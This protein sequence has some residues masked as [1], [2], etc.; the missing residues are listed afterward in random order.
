MGAD[1]G[2][3]LALLGATN[4]NLPLVGLGLGLKGLGALKSRKKNREEEAKRV[5]SVK[6]L[7]ELEKAG[8]TQTGKVRI[9]S[10]GPSKPMSRDILLSQLC[11]S[12]LAGYSLDE[13][14]SRCCV[15]SSLT[16][17]P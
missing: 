17:D 5:K 11:S 7:Q 1:I 16:D 14:T 4:G 15:Q 10:I 8:I 12:I 9:V 13:L 6:T 2:G 3:T